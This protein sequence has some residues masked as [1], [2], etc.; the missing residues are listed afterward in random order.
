ML[1]RDRGR[2]LPA[3][4]AIGLSAVLIAV[5]C[6]LVLGLVVITSTPIDHRGPQLWILPL[7]APSLH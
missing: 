6:G 1:W 3:L 2:S 4:M 5:H 7:E